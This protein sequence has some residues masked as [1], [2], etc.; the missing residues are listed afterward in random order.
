MKTLL[1]LQF[2][3]SGGGPSFRLEADRD[4]SHYGLHEVLNVLRQRAH[5]HYTRKD[6]PRRDLLREKRL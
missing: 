6:L 3:S 2:P 5:V 1:I 4:V